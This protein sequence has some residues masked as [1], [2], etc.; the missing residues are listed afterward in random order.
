MTASAVPAAATIR[1]AGRVETAVARASLAVVALHVVDDNFL[2]PQPGTS[3]A[4]HLVSGL[5]PLGAVIASLVGYPSLRAG[6]RATLALALGV[7]SIVGGAGEAGY[8]A[9]EVGLSG[10]DYTGLLMIPAG[11]ALV[12]LGALTLWRTRKTDDR[13]RRRSLRRL[14][15]ALAAIVVL[16][17][18]I[19]PIA[20]SYVITHAARAVVPEPRLGAAH[21]DVT[22]TTSD[23]L[24]LSGWYVPSRNGAAV[25]AF[26]GR[27]GP[28]R[29]ARMLVGHGYGVLLFDRRG[30]GESEG[31]PNTLGWGL[32]RDLEAALAFLE[33]RAD[34]EPGRIGGIGL[35]VG[36]ELLLEAAAEDERLA[37][38]VS[39]GAGIR[40]AREAALAPGVQRVI[41]LPI[42]TTTTVATAVFSNHL[43]PPSLQDVVARIAPRPVFLIY[44]GNGQGGEELS[45]DYFE[46]A[47]EPKTL[48]EIPEAGHTGGIE[49][50][51]AEYE[52]RVTTFFDRAL[53]GEGS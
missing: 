53:L 49:A 24:E 41:A 29:Q 31:D 3:A 17:V 20:Q 43:P 4:D 10:D 6:L 45:A 50:R 19:F 30:E 28:Q 37:A 39:E 38:V 8:Y 15:L 14:G 34:V 27:S 5:V 36:G 25:I 21:E 7:L 9:R 26:P 47:G 1:A 23:G 35:S 32:V 42:W 48:W 52:R 11:I 33:R 13:L 22:L 12:S 46:A 2:Q 51:P 44:A 18:V 16:A 40:S